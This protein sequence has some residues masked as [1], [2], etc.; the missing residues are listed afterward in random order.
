MAHR[1]VNGQDHEQRQLPIR[2]TACMARAKRTSGTVDARMIRNIPNNSPHSLTYR[3][4][5]RRYR[6][7]RDTPTRKRN[8]RPCIFQQEQ[9]K[10]SSIPSLSSA[11]VALSLKL[12]LISM[13]PN[14]GFT[15]GI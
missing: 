3:S 5:I 12:P 6:A 7:V 1:R 8:W 9:S 10:N 13:I 15:P 4:V 14:R 11:P 2:P